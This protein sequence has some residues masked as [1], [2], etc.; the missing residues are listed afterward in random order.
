MST[1]LEEARR[2]VITEA[3]IKV[4]SQENVSPEKVL[5][6]IAAGKANPSPAIGPALGQHGVNI[7]DFW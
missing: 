3:M 5:E 1:Q 2:G 7:M 6:Q 4:A